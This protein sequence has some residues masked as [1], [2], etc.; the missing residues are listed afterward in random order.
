MEP[1]GQ[2]VQGA[3]PAGEKLPASHG[4]RH[5]AWVEAPGA[6]V[7]NPEPQDMH[8]REPLRGENVLKGHGL[9]GERPFS[10]NEPIG[11]NSVIIRAVVTKG[12]DPCRRIG[13]LTLQKPSLSRRDRACKKFGG[14]G[15]GM[16]RWRKV[17]TA[18]VRLRKRTQRYMGLF[19][20][21]VHFQTGYRGTTMLRQNQNWALLCPRDKPCSGGKQR[22]ARKCLLDKQSKARGRPRRT[23]QLYSVLRGQ[24]IS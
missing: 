7:S 4:R 18:P 11:Q 24:E 21:M 3:R 15:T 5:A 14:G 2:R 19:K 16:C 13:T 12:T 8:V 23:R 10:E 9:Q 20:S 22:S 6:S 1:I 17:S